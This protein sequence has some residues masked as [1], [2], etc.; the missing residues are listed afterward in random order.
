MFVGE[1][2][3][4]RDLRKKELPII[5]K[6][7]NEPEVAVGMRMN[8]LIP[9]RDA[10]EEKWYE[11]LEV[12]GIKACLFTIENKETKEFM[13]GCGLHDISGKNRTGVVGIWIAK[14]FCGK[15]FGTDAMKVLLDIAFWEANLNKVTLNV[16]GYNK[17]AIRSYEK[18]G[19]KIEGIFRE[20][21][22]R[23]GTYHDEIK[24]GIL[25][26]EWEEQKNGKPVTILGDV[27]ALNNLD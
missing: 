21:F 17:R 13:G 10:D 1:N 9:L 6:Y 2:V 8:C 7:F 18:V 16:Y 3:R 27:S 5:M 26:K 19:F 12:D 22:Y 23:F 15:G 25:R 20:Q 4:L 11:G 14:Q 24:M